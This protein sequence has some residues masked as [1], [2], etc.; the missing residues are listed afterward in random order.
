MIYYN[1]NV[2]QEGEKFKATIPTRT[3]KI[4][5]YSFYELQARLYNYL[6]LESVENKQD[7][8]LLFLFKN[9]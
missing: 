9:E 6:D 5:A 1:V 3:H 2:E 4:V 8:R 7:Y